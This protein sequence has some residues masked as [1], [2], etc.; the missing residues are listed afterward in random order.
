MRDIN[1]GELPTEGDLVDSKGP[2]TTEVELGIPRKFNHDEEGDEDSQSDF[3]YGS[4]TFDADFEK[5]A[6]EKQKE[7]KAAAKEE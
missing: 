6:E 3:F 4:H 5:D 7:K 2:K 1:S